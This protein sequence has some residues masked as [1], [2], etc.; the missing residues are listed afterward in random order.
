[1]EYHL[2]CDT[3]LEEVDRRTSNCWSWSGHHGSQG[4]ARKGVLAGQAPARMG[5]RYLQLGRGSKLGTTVRSVDGFVRVGRLRRWTDDA[6][7][8]WLRRG[9]GVEPKRVERLIRDP[10]T[11][12]LRFGQASVLEVSASE[13]AAYWQRIEPYVRGKVHRVVGD[14]ADDHFECEVSEFRDQQRRVAVTVYESC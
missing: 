2:R 1:M 4:G 5:V 7:V 14:K 11:R 13:R 9:E 12:V 10:V 3:P 8:E 6:G